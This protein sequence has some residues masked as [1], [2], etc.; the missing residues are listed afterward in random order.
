MSANNRVLTDPKGKRKDVESDNESDSEDDYSYLSQRVVAVSSKPDK[1]YLDKLEKTYKKRGE[2]HIAQ[3]P[4]QQKQKP[5]THPSQEQALVRD[6]DVCV[7]VIGLP[8][9]LT[10]EEAF[11]AVFGIFKEPTVWKIPGTL[12]EV[13]AG[14]DLFYHRDQLVPVQSPLSDLSINYHG[15]LRLSSDRMEIISHGKDFEEYNTRLREA[16]DKAVSTIPE[17][18]ILI[19]ESMLKG[20]NVENPIKPLSQDYAAEYKEAFQ[21][22]C[23]R[24]DQEVYPYARRADEEG[25]IQELG[26]LPLPLQ[27]WQMQILEDAG[28]YVSIRQYAEERLST[29]DEIPETEQPGLAF[30][31]VCIRQLLPELEHDVSVRRYHHSTPRALHQDGH[32]LLAQPRPCKTCLESG[33]S[34]WVGPALVRIMQEYDKD[35]DLDKIFWIYDWEKKAAA[36]RERQRISSQ[37]GAQNVG[38]GYENDSLQVN[39]NGA[40]DLGEHGEVAGYAGSDGSSPDE[41]AETAASQGVRFEGDGSYITHSRDEI[42]GDGQT[43]KTSG[44]RNIVSEVAIL[45]C[46][47]A[48]EE[49]FD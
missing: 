33:C 47:S 18:A 42:D 19:M 2:L 38:A 14:K 41:F 21:A 35:A 49:A 3:K 28:A 12:F 48:T 27:D 4:K 9:S 24:R 29:A 25:L 45:H 13:F 31:N 17:L 39:I 40:D 36:E 7:H 34:C 23:G 10:A 32:I 22:A 1:F 15:E 44:S 37:R 6:D 26:F 5:A 46:V 43:V 30:L 11:S 20:Q 16:I 8:G